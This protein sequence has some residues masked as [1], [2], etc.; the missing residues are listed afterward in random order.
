MIYFSLAWLY[1]GITLSAVNIGQEALIQD[2]P[3]ARFSRFVNVRPGDGEVVSLNPPRFSWFYSPRAE[4]RLKRGRSLKGSYIFTFQ[5]S[6][7][8][9]FENPVVDVTTPYNFYNTLPVLRGSGRWFWRIGYN[10][11]LKNE[12]WSPT[13]SLTI[14]P[15]AVEWDRA[16]LAT[17]QF[18]GIGHPR[19]LF[20]SRN[21]NEIRRLRETHSESRE[22]FRMMEK[23]AG[24]ILKSDWW[25]DFP[26]TDDEPAPE[27]F[28]RIARDLALA[29]FL[30]V[31]TEE[32]KYAGVKERAITLASYP[33]GGRASP[34]RA[35]GESAEDST[36]ITE[37]LAL[38]FDWLYPQLSEDERYT[39]IKSLEWR[40]DYWMNEF[41]WKSKDVV[42]RGKTKVQ[43]SSLST[44]CSS[45]QYEGSMDTAPAGVALYGH[46]TIVGQASSLPNRKQDTAL[47]NGAGC[48]TIGKAWFE[49]ILN[50]LIGV[51]NG[52]GF[53][54][55]WN[56]GPGYG[57]S[58]MKWLMNASIYFDTAL[59][60]NLGR[61]PYYR[62]IGD[63]FCRI[64]PVGLQHSPWGNGS[65]RR[66][67]YASGRIS[68]F[69]KLAFLTG[70]G[71]FLR[72]WRET[73]GK[74][75]SRHRPWIEYV[76]P[77]YYRKPEEAIENE[78]VKV[79]PIAGWVTAST[80][81]PNSR[82][83]FEEA[84]GIIFQARPRGGY[85]HSFNSD[86]SFQ[87]YAYGQQLNH[88]GGSTENLDAFA[89]HTMSHT[90]ILVD[91][92]GQAQSGTGQL[93][94]AYSNITAFKKSDDFVYFAGDITNAYPHR[95]GYYMRWGLP[96]NKVYAERDV[97]HLRRL[98]RHVLFVRGKYFVI[99]DDIATARPATFTWLYHIL[100]EQPFSF[101]QREFTADYVVGDVNVR[102]VHVAHRENLK[103]DDRMSLRTMI[104]P[105]T[106]EDYREHRKEGPTP[107]HN[108][109]IS[110]VEPKEQFQFLAVIFPYR[111]GEA[112][113]TIQR[114]DDLTVRVDYD[115]HI[116]LIT[117][118]PEKHPDANFTVDAKTIGIRQ[119][120]E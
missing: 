78:T 108:L 45:H 92:L 100:P 84:V 54:E 66:N 4:E 113:P 16:A 105:F 30:W 120:Q 36:Q 112:A 35:G 5:I 119:N 103:L 70:D 89:Y 19:I 73:G 60:A 29:A 62:A 49:L 81:S 65:A 53:D 95:P 87:L 64:T 39:M 31:M 85:S 75:S 38:L 82:K 18:E 42:W 67:Y 37:F 27:E 102:L 55:A 2:N 68:N 23:E 90:T 33:R 28:V 110:N 1:A 52:F 58:K 13:Y 63:F 8:P 56:E 109:W 43:P 25:N 97:S 107:E 61:N 88:G 20:N 77:Y 48:A 71:R 111:A 40:V 69:R 17:P 7:T 14:A 115:K 114:V 118:A 91:G 57:N 32:P 80:H 46:S 117:F 22:I 106:S 93:Y 41:A 9:D 94:P 51:T 98:I 96:L 47:K 104:N 59:N 12:W 24:R 76:L 101:N 34:E 11:R 83:A 3:R 86:G 74:I 99:F 79:F 72:N 15:D 21:I 44:R 26:E 116:D 10:V 50:Y 6:A